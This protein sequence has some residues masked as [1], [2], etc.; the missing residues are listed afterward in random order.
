MMH[1]AGMLRFC[2]T[3]TEMKKGLLHRMAWQSFFVLIRPT[4]DP[5]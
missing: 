1:P 2:G 5:I 3:G 4:G